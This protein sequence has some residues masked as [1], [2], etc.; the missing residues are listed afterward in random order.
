MKKSIVLLLSI[1]I[2]ILAGCSK[3]APKTPPSAPNTEENADA[4]HLTSEDKNL[5]ISVSKEIRSL[6][7][8][9]INTKPGYDVTSILVAIENVSKDNVPISPKFVTLKTTDETEYK[10]SEE[11]TMKITSKSA[12]KEVILPPDY[13][14]GGLLVFEIK[15]DSVP[16]TLSY[17]DNSGHEMTVQFPAI[18]KKSI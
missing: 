16:D 15:K 1:F 18:L 5:K 17:K 7:A 3:T 8:M 14:G 11:L 4:A 9:N 6:T 2:L 10:Y 13:R 12:F